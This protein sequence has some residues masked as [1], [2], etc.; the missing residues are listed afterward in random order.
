M[1]DSDSSNSDINPLTPQRCVKSNV[2]VAY[3]RVPRSRYNKLNHNEEDVE[4]VSIN[5]PQIAEKLSSASDSTVSEHSKNDNDKYQ[6]DDYVLLTKKRKGIIRFIGNVE[7]TKG[8]LYGIE[9]LNKLGK[10]DGM[11]NNIRYFHTADK[12]AVFVRE[13]IIKNKIIPITEIKHKI[14]PIT[15]ETVY[16]DEKLRLNIYTQGFDRNSKMGV[17]K[18]IQYWADQGQHFDIYQIMSFRWKSQNKWKSLD[19]LNT[20][21]K[22]I[23]CLMIQLPAIIFICFQLIKDT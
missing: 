21:G 7:F 15:N 19:F 2:S 11:K 4:N 16:S 6:I 23:L 5:H 12:R 3:Q 8:K 22:A 17:I 10:H 9:L 20:I 1:S 14:I 18:M 13:N